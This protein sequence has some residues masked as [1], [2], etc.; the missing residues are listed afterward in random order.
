LPVATFQTAE[1]KIFPEVEHERAASGMIWSAEKALT[2]MQDFLKWI[3]RLG[4]LFFSV[5]L[6]ERWMRRR[7][8]LS[9]TVI[10]V[11]V[12]R[13]APPGKRMGHAGAIISRD[14]G[15]AAHTIEMVREAGAKIA[16]DF[17][18]LLELAQGAL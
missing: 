18:H 6:R 2:V 16:G 7:C 9:E 11:I 13:T 10:T 4:L 1:A 3:T 8:T 14:P 15:S 17:W 5:R 12:G